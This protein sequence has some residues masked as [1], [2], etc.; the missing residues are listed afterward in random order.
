M[1]ERLVY[2]QVGRPAAFHLTRPEDIA[3]LER[4]A[5]SSRLLALWAAPP[6]F[7]HGDLA[8]DNVFVTPDGY[9]LI[10]WQRPL[11]GPAGLD[12]VN[13]YESLGLNPL[14]C[15]EASRVELAWFIRLRW[16]LDCQT[17][18]FPAGDYDPQVAELAHKIIQAK[19][20]RQ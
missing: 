20:D 2:G 16:F 11:R 9:K 10:D 5:A 6:A 4:W 15:L 14:G 13:F 8:G 7:Q 19:E 3:G 18:F 17:R 12:L 1:L